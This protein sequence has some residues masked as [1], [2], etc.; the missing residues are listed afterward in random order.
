MDQSEKAGRF[1]ELHVKGRPVLLYN[2]WDAGSAKAI[3]AAGVKAIAT[4]S[5]S[6]AEAQGYR[7][8]EAIPIGLVEQIVGRIATTIDAPVT[9]DF[10]GGYSDDDELAGNIARLLDLG[11]IGINFEDRVV[12]GGGLYGIARQAERISTIRETAEER[13][14]KLFINARTDVFFEHGDDAAGAVPE[15]LERAKT[16]TAAGAS[17][18]FV[19]GL[20]DAAMIGQIVEGTPLPVNVM[21][22]DG[23]PSNDRL[24][25]LG[26]VRIS[27]GPIPY[28]R[29]LETL[30]QEAKSVLGAAAPRSGGC[31]SRRRRLGRR[32]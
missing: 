18:L 19:P 30:E 20:V 27:Y 9:V 14:V 11:V 1:A 23:V 2:A 24:A 28:I 12:E 16:Y 6:V 17:G 31:G 5:W 7:D 13:G 10:E 26:V 4:S 22:M 32:A 8:G 25:E 29:A 15:A 3:L 21:V